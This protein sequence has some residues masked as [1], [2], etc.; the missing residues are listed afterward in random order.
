MDIP[1]HFYPKTQGF[2]PIGEFPHTVPSTLKGL[3][4]AVEI[5]I[6]AVSALSVNLA[7]MNTLLQKLPGPH[8]SPKQNVAVNARAN[9]PAK[10]VG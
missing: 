4:R 5:G 8:H 9:T 2:I 3:E 1:F 10:F 7:R 6:I